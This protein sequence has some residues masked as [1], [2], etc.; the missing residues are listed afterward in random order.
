MLK[1]KVF[2]DRWHDIAEGQQQGSSL[3]LVAFGSQGD[4]LETKFLIPQAKEVEE[5]LVKT[6]QEL[7]NVMTSSTPAAVAASSSSSDSESDHEHSE[8]NSTYSA[9]L[10]SQGINDHR[11]E[12]DRLTEAEKN[13]RLQA[14]LRVRCRGF[15]EWCSEYSTLGGFKIAF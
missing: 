14:K 5:N 8:E 2:D 7:R 4:P 3:P 11:R 15:G 12:E 9:E 10:H 13:E 1:K 6:Q